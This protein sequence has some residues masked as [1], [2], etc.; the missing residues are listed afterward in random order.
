MSWK[1][2]R[3]MV[4]LTCA[5][6]V[7]IA[8]SMTP[9]AASQEMS[10]TQTMA[11]F[12]K[13]TGSTDVLAMAP[14]TGGFATEMMAIAQGKVGD[15]V[16]TEKKMGFQLYAEAAVQPTTST[17]VIVSI[18]ATTAE[19]FIAPKSYEWPDEVKVAFEIRSAEP[20]VVLLC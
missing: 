2:L 3:I 10:A 13:T 20:V 4:A 1:K 14:G 18:F 7:I 17:E 12:D 6:L 8:G 11:V 5:V 9:A 16:V 19:P 15:V